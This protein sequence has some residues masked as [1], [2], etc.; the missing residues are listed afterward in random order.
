MS[1]RR[2]DGRFDEGDEETLAR[3]AAS[4][5]PVPLRESLERLFHNL[6]APPVSVVT[7]LQ[8]RWPDLVGPALADATRP[9]DLVDGVLTVACSD[10]AWA[11]QVQWMEAQIKARFDEVF[12]PDR[13][14]RVTVRVDR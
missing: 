14:Q 13:L 4:R 7:G 11:A 3:L 6:G 8:E 5:P 1:P 2:F 9:V 10:G 12:G